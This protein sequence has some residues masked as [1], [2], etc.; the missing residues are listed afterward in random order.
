MLVLILLIVLYR[1]LLL[2][3]IPLIGVGFAYGAVN[4]LLG[5]MTANGWII[6]DSQAISIMTVL[7]FRS[8]W[9]FSLWV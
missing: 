3:F 8:V 2:A 7:Q 5:W 4:P 1:S 9:L 6:V